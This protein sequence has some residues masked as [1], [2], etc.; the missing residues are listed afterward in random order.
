MCLGAW[1][2]YKARQEKN[3]IPQTND[4]L[5]CESIMDDSL[6]ESYSK[7][8]AKWNGHELPD[9]FVHGVN[10]LYKQCYRKGNETQKKYLKDLYNKLTE[11]KSKFK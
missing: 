6:D 3:E 2:M 4:E 1:A 11:N 7:K 8:W 10:E 9:Q 5:K